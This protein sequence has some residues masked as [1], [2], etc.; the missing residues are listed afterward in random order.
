[1]TLHDLP[2]IP[3]RSETEHQ[4][5][6]EVM[7]RAE[8]QT[9][10]TCYIDQLRAFVVEHAAEFTQGTYA[11]TLQRSDPLKRIVMKAAP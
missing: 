9:D 5:P 2:P 1:M 3:L 4:Q 7:F 8:M 6:C 10:L 11:L